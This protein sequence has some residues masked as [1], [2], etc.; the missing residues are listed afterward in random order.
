MLCSENPESDILFMTWRFVLTFFFSPSCCSW[1]PTR[2]SPICCQYS[3][4]HSLLLWHRRPPHGQYW[5]SPWPWCWTAV[6]GF[7]HCQADSQWKVSQ[8]R[9]GLFT[10]VDFSW[11][12][13]SFLHVSVSQF[14][15]HVQ[16]W[17]GIPLF[18]SWNVLIMFWMW[19]WEWL[20]GFSP[21][22][23]LDMVGW[24]EIM[25]SCTSR[26][27]LSAIAAT[28]APL[29][30]SEIWESS[31]ASMY[32]LQGQREGEDK[33]FYSTEDKRTVIFSFSKVIICVLGSTRPHGISPLESNNCIPFEKSN[34]LTVKWS[35][36]NILHE[37]KHWINSW[38]QSR[39]GSHAVFGFFGSPSSLACF[40]SWFHGGRG[41]AWV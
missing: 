11:L 37:D 33:R 38:N 5:R 36:K 32:T 27:I 24:P 31:P 28:L 15:R 35:W 20:Q 23:Q 29:L 4:R 8:L 41:N 7:G 30:E 2:W 19:S 22:C 40:P 21:I 17:K 16:L 10:Q 13:L 39:R 9:Y 34:S 12:F 26:F 6:H 14:L 3:G 18:S 1:V 25:M